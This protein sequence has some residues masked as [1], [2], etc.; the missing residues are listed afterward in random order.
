MPPTR[1]PQVQDIVKHLRG[2]GCLPFP[3]GPLVPREV[4]GAHAP[5]PGQRSAGHA[6]DVAAA[7]LAREITRKDDATNPKSRLT[8]LMAHAA[9]AWATR[10]PGLQDPEIARAKPH[11]ANAMLQA[12]HALRA[13]EDPAH[14][15]GD[16]EQAFLAR[17]QLRLRPPKADRAPKD[18]LT[19]VAFTAP[20]YRC[21]CLDA[22]VA[23][24]VSPLV[25]TQGHEAVSKLLDHPG[26]EWWLLA[27]VFLTLLHTHLGWLP[28]AQ[29]NATRE[30]AQALHEPAAHLLTWRA[31]APAGGSGPDDGPVA[32]G[33]A[34]G[35][36][37][38]VPSNAKG[39][40]KRLPAPVADMVPDDPKAVLAAALGLQPP[41]T[42]WHGFA[43]S[44]LPAVARLARDIAADLTT[45]AM[46]MHCGLKGTSYAYLAEHYAARHKQFAKWARDA[47]AA[48]A[49]ALGKHLGMTLR[50][51]FARD[52]LLPRMPLLQSY[53]RWM[54]EDGGLQFITTP[55]PARAPTAADAT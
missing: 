54:E 47:A 17:F 43:A 19:N 3:A 7:F 2:H 10:H 27:R 45:P 28:A 39:L 14:R 30:E 49:A 35:L 6:A 40:L 16:V 23:A 13:T 32:A 22:P 25:P 34:A 24:E 44:T 20:A 41:G 55:Q 33:I 52:A 8:G 11:P 9:I 50:A 46:A 21:A 53:C 18:A 42:G 48:P 37:W 38:A 5:A 36:G 15:R 26:A 1:L 31:I 4:E 12:L 29:G 51:S